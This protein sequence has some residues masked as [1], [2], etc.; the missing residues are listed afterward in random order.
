LALKIRL[1]FFGI[2]T[3]KK[4]PLKKNITIPFFRQHICN[5]FC[6]KCYI[7]PTPTYPSNE[8]QYKQGQARLG[9]IFK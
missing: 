8:I 3:L 4:F 1:A 9:L 2:F 7:R 6:N 5:L